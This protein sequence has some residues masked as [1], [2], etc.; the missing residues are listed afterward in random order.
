MLNTSCLIYLIL[1]TG[2][3]D[4]F[5][6]NA[7]KWFGTYL[8]WIPDERAKVSKDGRG[9]KNRKKIDYYEILINTNNFD[10]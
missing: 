5:M 1:F 7:F 10:E 6:L 2:K 4:L 8:A 3:S 9:N